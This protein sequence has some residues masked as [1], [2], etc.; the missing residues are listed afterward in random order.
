MIPTWLRVI[1]L[2]L[3]VFI[4]FWIVLACAAWPEPNREQ[5]ILVVCAMVLTFL[6]FI[7]GVWKS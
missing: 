3:S 4:G 7:T 5:A 6:F 2:L 1:F